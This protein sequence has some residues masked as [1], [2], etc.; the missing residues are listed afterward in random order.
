MTNRSRVQ[1]AL[2]MFRNSFHINALQTLNFGNSSTV[3][4][5]VHL[6][7]LFYHCFHRGAG[8]SVLDSLV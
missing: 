2:F 6:S 3:N 4:Q 1:E 8:T 7:L 5:N